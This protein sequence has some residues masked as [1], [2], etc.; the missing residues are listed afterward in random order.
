MP[1]L[2]PPPPEPAVA[3]YAEV[4]FNRPLTTRFTYGVPENL[5]ARL[6]PGMRVRAPFGRGNRLLPGYCVA[7]SVQPRTDRSVK[8]LNSIIDDEPLL[9]P[10][11]L[12]LTQWLA[13]YYLC[14]WGQA[15]DAAIPAGAKAQA[16]T[17]QK[18]FV[19]AVPLD[20]L[21]PVPTTLTRKQGLALAALREAGGPLEADALAEQ[22]GCG[23]SVV[24]ALVRQGYATRQTRRV[25]ATPLEELGLGHTPEPTGPVDLTEHQRQALAAIDAALKTGGFKPFLLH[26]VTGSGKTEVYL[27]AIAQVV[28][29]GREALVL[30][31][32]ISL[33]PQAIER[34]AGRFPHIAVLH[35]HLTGPE[36]GMHWRR[37]ARGEMQ[38]VI[39]AR[40]A[41]FAPTRRLGLIVVDEEHESSFKQE[42]TPRYHARDLAVRRAQQLGIPVVLG[43]A[44]PA[45]ESWHNVQRGAYTLLSLP[46][47]VEGRPLPRVQIVDLRHEPMRRGRFGA[48][49]PS[50]ERAMHITLGQGGQIILFLNR[51]GFD[52]YLYC[53]KCGCVVKCRFCD[54]ALTHHRA[55][56]A[57]D[58]S[59]AEP[60]PGRAVC[61]YCGFRTA[62]PSDCPECPEGQI[63]YLGLGTEKLEEELAHKFPGVACQRMDSDSMRRGGS[64]ARALEAFRRGDTRILFGTQMIAKGLDFPGVTLVGVVNAD[65]ALHLPDFRAAERTFQLLAQVAGRTGR[66]EQGGIVLVQTLT[67]EHPCIHMAS[68][69]DYESFARWELEQRRSHGYPPL[70]RLARVLVRGREQPVV[71]RHVAELAERV[72]S[73]LSEGMTLL[74]PAEAPLKKLEG[75]HRWHFLIFSPTARELH[76]VL[77]EH[78]LSQPTPHRVEVAIDVDPQAML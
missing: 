77:R 76:G 54:V 71:A 9:G 3:C 5:A 48:I 20:L 28:A 33:T 18:A 61:H 74:G 7:L 34:F 12:D 57:V 52:T 10:D 14:G 65:T 64:H 69:H 21:R 58:E 24:W 46:H 22:V 51:R 47:R 2:F 73:A 49:G 35:S 4:V 72:R 75:W 29:A 13:D 45:L 38:V 43:S 1:E 42:T 30:V 16:G 23:L 36:R 50:L 59:A 53:P 56:R 55:P 68:R 67:P 31:P 66:G 17:R 27:R 15:L 26:G 8:L 11:L 40:S 70:R 63:R 25:E 6:Q 62:P 39:G 37:I 78:V 32:E 19:T 44:T 60:R 41:I